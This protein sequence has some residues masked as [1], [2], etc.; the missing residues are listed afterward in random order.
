MQVQLLQTVHQN[1]M[2][3]EES[4]SPEWSTAEALQNEV[5]G[6]VQDDL[7]YDDSPYFS[8]RGSSRRY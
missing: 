5:S 2:Q 8:F 7:S 6:H 4:N 1:E 3:E